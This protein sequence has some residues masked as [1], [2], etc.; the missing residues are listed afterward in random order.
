MTTAADARSD[1]RSILDLHPAIDLHADTLMWSR[2]ISYDLLARHTPPL[3]RA[4]LGGHV[5]IPRMRTGG[6]GAQFFGLVS[7]PFF[8]RSGGMARTVHEQIDA[9]DEAIVRSRGALRKVRTADEIAQCQQDGAIS[10]L[11][12]IEGAHTLEGSIDALDT[13]ARRGV[14]YL[15]LSHFSANEACYPA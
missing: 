7:L 2:W 6:M 4:A 12:G 1:G 5:D 9:L 3:P 11:L 8:G 10:A 15:G 14:R 13:F